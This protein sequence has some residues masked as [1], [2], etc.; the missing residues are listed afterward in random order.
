[1][2]TS[3]YVVEMVLYGLATATTEKALFGC[4]DVAKPSQVATG[5]GLR[6][7][8][9]GLLGV[10]EGLSLTGIAAG[11]VVLALQVMQR[12]FPICSYP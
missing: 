11:L 1:M 7:G 3:Y 6:P 2:C 9:G 10:V 12:M 8:P 5:K 4:A